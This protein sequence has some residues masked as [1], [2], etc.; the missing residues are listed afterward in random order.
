MNNL[1]II[2]KRFQALKKTLPKK[3]GNLAVIFTRQRFLEQA[4]VDVHSEPWPRRKVYKNK[5]DR[6]RAILIKTGRLWRGNRITHIGDMTV[7]IG[8]AVPYAKAHNNG[9]RGVVN[10]RQHSRKRFRREK[11]ETGKF[12]K[13]GKPR[14][15]TV[16]R[17]S[18]VTIVKAHTMRMNLPRRRYMGKSQYLSNQIKRLISAEIKSIFK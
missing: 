4:W 10:V 2:Q 6:S 1:A 11:V 17:V 5:R 18:G 15:K 8:N 13:R 9:F 7:T 16:K 3:V 14:T 12:T